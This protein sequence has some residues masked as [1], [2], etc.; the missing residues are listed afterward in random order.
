[1]RR[2]SSNPAPP[3]VDPTLHPARSLRKKLVNVMAKAP[4]PPPLM[5]DGGGGS[6][7]V[8]GQMAL[9]PSSAPAGM[10]AVTPEALPLGP[11]ALTLRTIAHS[12]GAESE[13]ST[14]SLTLLP[15]SP[16]KGGAGDPEG[17]EGLG[18]TG[19]FGIPSPRA[20]ASFSADDGEGTN[21]G[22]NMRQQI[23]IVPV[24]L[25]SGA[26]EMLRAIRRGVI[27]LLGQAE[28]MASDVQVRETCM[29]RCGRGVS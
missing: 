4:T 24:D 19:D 29:C 3:T 1:M 28:A 10:R 13:S 16:I 26:G 15:A 17:A 6:N 25:G 9:S 5:R 14:K 18:G 27:N 11:L 2:A 21:P 20:E 8:R 23:E 7:K 12:R 22:G